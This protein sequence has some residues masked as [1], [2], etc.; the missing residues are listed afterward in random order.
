MNF[1]SIDIDG[2]IAKPLFPLRK[3]SSSLYGVKEKYDTK[4]YYSFLEK[5][6][7]TLL[8]YPRK[9]L[10]DARDAFHLLR[11]HSFA[12]MLNSSRPVFLK[13][14]TED[15]LEEKGLQGFINH[16]SLRNAKM[17][18]VDAKADAIKLTNAKIHIDD[19]PHIVQQLAK[20]D[21]LDYIIFLTKNKRDIARFKHEKKV[22]CAP[23]LSKAAETIIS[24]QK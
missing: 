14:M 20:L 6:I 21:I 16:V 12:I 17:K 3:I 13:E 7:H 18:P 23:S 2:V 15:W 22:L 5:R 1:I 4:G 19:D 10:P 11:Q 9:T 24:M 8:H